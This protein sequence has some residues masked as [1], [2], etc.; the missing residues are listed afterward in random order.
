[1]AWRASSRISRRPR[2]S[3]QAAPVLE[4][5]E[6][7]FDLQPT[8]G[9]GLSLCRTQF[10]DAGHTLHALLV[11]FERRCDDLPGCPILAGR[12]RRGPALSALP[13]MISTS[14]PGARS[15]TLVGKFLCHAQVVD[16][17][18]GMVGPVL[19]QPVRKLSVQGKAVLCQPMVQ[20]GDGGH[21]LP[22]MD[23]ELPWAGVFVGALDVEAAGGSGTVL[24]V[25]GRC[26]R[27]RCLASRRIASTN[28]STQSSQVQ[29]TCSKATAVCD[30]PRSNDTRPSPMV[31]RWGGG[32]SMTICMR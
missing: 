2:W 18:A 31:W 27:R 17:F 22:G 26:T 15:R 8:T 24:A 20:F 23:A 7:V 12:R 30:D 29:S 19:V 4:V 16:F 3:G 32:A 13:R 28:G 11:M 21:G 6:A 9:V 14:S 5:R 1:M 25:Q 10:R